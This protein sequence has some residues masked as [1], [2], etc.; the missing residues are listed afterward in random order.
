VLW[1]E[2]GEKERREGEREG[3]REG[4]RDREGEKKGERE[5]GE[6]DWKKGRRER[7]REG[8]RER[9][10]EGGRTGERNYIWE[11]RSLHSQSQLSVLRVLFHTAKLRPPVFQ[12]VSPISVCSTNTTY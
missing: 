5:E 11:R 6:R 8:G 3:R 7:G 2:R 10:R 1:K 12:H 9:G 4:K